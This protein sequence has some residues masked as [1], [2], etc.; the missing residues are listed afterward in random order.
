VLF[1][2]G[3]A[4]AAETP[5]WRFRPAELVNK[6]YNKELEKKLLALY[7]KFEIR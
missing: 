6:I 4:L 7:R 3:E 5:E 2:S 1:R